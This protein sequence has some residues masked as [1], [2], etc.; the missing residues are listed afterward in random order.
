MHHLLD[1]GASPIL[2][3]QNGFDLLQR[4]WRSTKDFE[5]ITHLIRCGANPNL[6]NDQGVFPLDELMIRPKMV[7]QDV[8]DPRFSSKQQKKLASQRLQAELQLSLQY[9]QHLEL[10]LQN[11]ADLN[12]LDCNGRSFLSKAIM[13]RPHPNIELVKMLLQHGALTDTQDRR[14]ETALHHAV[15]YYVT[16]DIVSSILQY[17]ARIEFR[18]SLGLTAL[19]L[20]SAYGRHSLIPLLANAGADL[21]ARVQQNPSFAGFEVKNTQ[22]R[23]LHFRDG[24][25]ALHIATYYRQYECVKSLLDAG[26]VVDT[27][28]Q[29]EQTALYCA[30]LCYGKYLS[31][32]QEFYRDKIQ[33]W[34]TAM[35]KQAEEDEAQRRQGKDPKNRNHKLEP[36][37]PVFRSKADLAR[38]F[39]PVI[40]ELLRHGASI[41]EVVRL[42]IVQQDSVAKSGGLSLQDIYPEWRSTV[43]EAAWSTVGMPTS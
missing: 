23:P 36:Q 8:V 12:L 43:T 19:H 28:N 2:A 38:G 31:E 13:Q 32:Y 37:Q 26:A 3:E 5:A 11:S 10:F 15:T 1:R 18:N 7:K 33:E 35:Q 16:Q 6:P 40:D 34:K 39:K 42:C 9:K 4:L 29:N 14:G 25:T 22:G 21:G 41:K 30:V 20:C 17:S 24:E 27:R